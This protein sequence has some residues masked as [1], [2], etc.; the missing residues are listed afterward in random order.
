MAHDTLTVTL[1]G[2]GDPSQEGA[3]LNDFLRVLGGISKAVR[4]MVEHLGG[5]ETNRVQTPAWVREQSLLQIAPLQSGSLAASVSLAHP[6]GGQL[7]VEGFGPR[8]IEALLNWD[9]SENSTLPEQ[10]TDCLFEATAGLGISTRVYLGSREQP[11]RLQVRQGETAVHTRSVFEPALLTGWLKE[12]NWNN[13]TAQLHDF[14]GDYV[15]LRFDQ[16]LGGEMLRLAT[17]HVRVRGQGRFSKGDEWT[18]VRVEQLSETRSWSDPFELDTL[19]EDPNARVFDPDN[20]VTADGPID[21]DEYL[22]EI[23]EGRDVGQSEIPE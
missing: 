20:I 18:A 15:R 19:L 3:D 4:L 1:E 17:R 8:A 12:V 5:R 9:G 2:S 7:R 23:H 21:V 13:G 14:G 16:S 10:V 22:R 6:N 11:K